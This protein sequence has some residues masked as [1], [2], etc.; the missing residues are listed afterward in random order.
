M[1]ALIPGMRRAVWLVRFEPRAHAR[2]VVR[3]P[4]NHH[5]QVAVLRHAVGWQILD[6]LLHLLAQNAR[7]MYAHVEGAVSRDQP[8][9]H[10]VNA[11]AQLTA[12][13]LLLHW[14]DGQIAEAPIRNLQSLEEL[15]LPLLLHLVSDGVV[16]LLDA[17]RDEFVRLRRLGPRE[18][19]FRDG[20]DAL[21]PCTLI[22]DV[23]LLHDNVDRARAQLEPTPESRTL[24]LAQQRLVD[25]QVALPFFGV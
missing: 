21:A 19:T 8:A 14:V 24:V 16:E 17:A 4:V 22:I 7:H 13:H 11:V 3:L 2:S 18:L 25:L 15:A 9:Q 1:R 10:V 6:R 20:L 12:A 23:E 5:S